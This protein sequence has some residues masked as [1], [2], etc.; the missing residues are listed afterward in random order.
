MS[1]PLCLLLTDGVLQSRV[2]IQTLIPLTIIYFFYAEES[3]ISHED[4]LKNETFTLQ[5]V[6]QATSEIPQTSL[7]QAKV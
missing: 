3:G 1:L 6:I 7:G 5:I 2:S 4:D